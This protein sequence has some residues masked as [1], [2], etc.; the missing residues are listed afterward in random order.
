MSLGLATIVGLTAAPQEQFPGTAD[1]WRRF[2]SPHC[3][4]FSQVGEQDSRDLLHQMEQLQALFGATMG[5]RERRVVPVTVYYFAR[6][7]D[8][9]PYVPEQLRD[10]DR[11]AAYHSRHADR[12]V[13][14]LAPGWGSDQTRRLVYHEYIHHIVSLADEH[15]PIWFSEGEAEFF[16]TFREHRDSLLVGDPI[17]GHIATIKYDGLMSLE[18]L[19]GIDHQSPSYNEASRAGLL[20]AESWLLIHYLMCG[21]PGLTPEQIERRQEFFRYLGQETDQGDPE[22][23]RETFERTIGMTYAQMLS[24]LREYIRRGQFVW[25][26]YPLPAIP[27]ATTYAM[28]SMP[29]E[30][31]RLRLAELDL[32][33]NQSAAGR[34]ALL[35]AVA[36]E[37]GEYRAREVLGMDA[38]R[39]NDMA[40]A[41][42]RW[43]E[44]L[45]AGSRNPA[46]YYELAGIEN[47]QWFARFDLDFRLPND[48]A[49]ELRRLLHGSLEAA[50]KQARAYEVLAWVEATAEKPSPREINLV[51]EHLSDVSNRARTL[52]ALAVIRVRV[53]DL[54]TAQLMLDA[55]AKGSTAP[56]VTSAVR[57]LQNII[58]RK[59]AK[60]DAS[61]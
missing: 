60:A 16:S 15:P 43:R 48:K 13:I 8:F 1:N 21:S 52:L 2:E 37:P 54:K 46:V 5:L 57:Q 26:K 44:A 39:D 25:R 20:Y 7:K 10:E 4:L 18:Q 55:L 28:R 41:Q 49:A 24:E 31:I 35:D 33:V 23:R 32:R 59:R 19:F 51:Q 36:R 40:R 50:P 30:E 53:G 42:E 47:Q 29:R 58:E 11:I 56:D 22:R 6:K 12:A 38:Q 9:L 27:E 14:V 17:P 45:T 61:N 3:E 34:L